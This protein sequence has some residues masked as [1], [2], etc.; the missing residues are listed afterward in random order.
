M[1]SIRQKRSIDFEISMRLR[2]LVLTVVLLLSGCTQKDAGS[3]RVTPVSVTCLPIQIDKQYFDKGVRP[4]AL[5][6][7]SHNQYANTNWQFHFKPRFEFDILKKEVKDKEMWVTIR[8]TSATVEIS[9]P[10]IIYLPEGV[11]D[12]VLHHELGHVKIC[13]RLYEK[14]EGVARQALSSVIGQTFEGKGKNLN[15]AC[16]MAL[17]GAS[18]SAGRIYRAHTVDVVNAVSTNYDYLSPQHPGPE[19]VDAV[20]DAAFQML[21]K[22]DELF[23]AKTEHDKRVRQEK[24]TK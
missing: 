19:H 20:V 23:S 17:D 11:S 2:S 7:A 22:R 18:Q 24:K 8:P 13:K 6:V 5:A 9:L 10:I 3:D 15:D 14:A 21:E 4:T 16:R 1:Y 12:E